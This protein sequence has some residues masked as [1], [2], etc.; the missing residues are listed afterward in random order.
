M[1]DLNLW[2]ES[3]NL[4]EDYV[5]FKQIHH[6][7]IELF[8]Q[9]SGQ[10]FNLYTIEHVFWYKGGN[11]LTSAAA[12]GDVRVEIKE[13]EPS[14]VSTGED[15][16]LVY[17]RLPESY[18]PPIIAI[19][20]RVARHEESLVEAAGRSG[21]TLERAF[22]K[23]IDAAFTVLGYETKLMG[24]GKGR[25]PDGMAVANDERYAIVW[26]AKIRTNGYSLGTDD[27]IIREYIHVQSRELKRRN[28]MRNIYYMI[29]S[30]T[31]AD[32]FDDAIRSI[33]ME[34]D[35]N[36]VCLVEAEALVAMV[37]AKLRSPLQI[38]LGS[39]GLQQLFA[40]SGILA[41]ENVKEFLI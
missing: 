40:N 1:K 34:T 32:D 38:S 7:L 28:S 20:P 12:G 26:D 11:P 25:V 6:E 36:E 5:T 8:S 18:I 17:S 15:S 4:G 10:S 39:D 16:L 19:L 30:S 9:T 24:Q 2:E 35:V 22:E 41:A 23:Y 27:R 29:I 13:S 14:D 3:G 33:K 31:F 21:T 37:D